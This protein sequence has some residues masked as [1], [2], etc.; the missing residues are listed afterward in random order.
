MAVSVLVTALL[1]EDVGSFLLA[2]IDM[3]E[4]DG[5]AFCFEKASIGLRV[6]CF[7]ECF[8]CDVGVVFGIGDRDLDL[9][10]TCKIGLLFGAGDRDLDLMIDSC[11]PLF[12]IAVKTY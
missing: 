8:A 4:A 1:L 3:C 2:G 12:C 5:I 10:Q 7:A 11:D 6:P 9:M